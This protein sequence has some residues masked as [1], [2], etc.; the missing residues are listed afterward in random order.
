M[1]ASSQWLDLGAR[2]HSADEAL[3]FSGAEEG[4]VDP[5]C[6]AKAIKMS[7][8]QV[9]ISSLCVGAASHFLSVNVP[10]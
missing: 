6:K 9:Q 5:G 10:L 7:L 3:N 8:N 2:P 4:G 1:G